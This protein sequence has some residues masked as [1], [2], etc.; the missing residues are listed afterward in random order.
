MHRTPALLLLALI[1]FVAFRSTTGAAAP[2]GPADAIYRGGDFVTLVDA[3]PTAEALAVKDGKIL[4]VGSLAEAEA[5]KGPATRVIDLG[6]KTMLPAFIDAHS[7]YINSLWVANQCKLYAPPAG[8]GKDVESIVAEL[9][10]FAAE[11]TSR[12]ARRSSGTA[13][14]TP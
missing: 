5:L 13:T 11:A 3:A 9:R 2:T 12:R 10:K 8:P 1:A 14:T 4:F 7:H 6:G